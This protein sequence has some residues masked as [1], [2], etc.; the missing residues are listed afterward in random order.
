MAK[1]RAILHSVKDRF[2]CILDLTAV[3]YRLC[4]YVSTIFHQD[5]SLNGIYILGISQLGCIAKLEV[6]V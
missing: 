5:G 3:D 1:V 4:A 2:Y 6:S